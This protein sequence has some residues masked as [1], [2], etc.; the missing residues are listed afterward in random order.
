M[1]IRIGKIE[2][3]YGAVDFGMLQDDLALAEVENMDDV[4]F[5]TAKYKATGERPVRIAVANAAQFGLKKAFWDV[6]SPV[7]G[8]AAGNWRVEKDAATGEEFISRRDSN[9][10]GEV[11]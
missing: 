6:Y 7:E 11:K 3:D 5:A 10:N 1:S 8:V 4:T 2:Q 9:L